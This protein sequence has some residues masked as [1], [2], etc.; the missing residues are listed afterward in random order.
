M[1]ITFLIDIILE[2]SQYSFKT[3]EVFFKS[4]Q[5]FA[6]Y[7]ICR[8]CVDTRNY[9]KSTFINETFSLF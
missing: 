2:F 3:F 7:S 1:P 5:K 4:S 6:M 8:Y 9:D